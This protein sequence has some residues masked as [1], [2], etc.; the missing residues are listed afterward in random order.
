MIKNYLISSLKSFENPVYRVGLSATYRPGKVTIFKALDEGIN[1]FFCFGIDS[2]MIKVLKDLS[3]SQRE[4]LIIATGAYNYKYFA[5]DIMKSFHKRCRQLNT[6][7]IDLYLFLGVLS[8]KELKPQI[9]ESMNKLKEDG[10]I[11]ATGISTHNRSLAGEL[12]SKDFFDV[13]MI[14][15]NAAH[16]GAE[17]DIFP[18]ID[19]HKVSIISYTATCWKRLLRKPKNYL[20]E[21]I[22][23]AGDCYRFVLGNDKVDVCLMAPRNIKEFNENLEQIKK[24]KLPD[25]DLKFIMEFGDLVYKEKKWFM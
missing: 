2:Q 22:P 14:R 8:E 23:S 21:R 7:Y 20:G 3:R 11:R 13:L 9:I 6:D 4:N 15:Y 24:G 19:H 18:K 10:K 17:L 25:D 12:V 5:Q 16:R 1:F